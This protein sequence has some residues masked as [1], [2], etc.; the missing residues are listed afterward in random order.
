MNELK[1]FYSTKDCDKCTHKTDCDLYQEYIH[2]AEN[3]GGPV[4]A[5]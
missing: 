2:L 1:C 3:G 4:H 5:D